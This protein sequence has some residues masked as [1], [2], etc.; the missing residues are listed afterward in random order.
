MPEINGQNLATVAHVTALAQRVK[1][2]LDGV[3]AKNF[4]DAKIEN[5]QLKLYAAVDASTPIK[6][7]DLP[8][9][10]YLD[11]VNTTFVGNFNFANGGYTGATNPNLDG[12]PVLVLAVKD[13]AT[14]P[15]VTY[16]FLNMES[17]V[18][19]YTALNDGIQITGYSIGVKTSADTDNL[20]SIANDGLL[21]GHDDTKIDTVAGAENNFVLFD[22]DGAIKDAGFTIA[23]T[24]DINTILDSI[25]GAAG[26]D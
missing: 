22:A 12:K 24:S 10:L 15:N 25:F 17:L 19:T 23:G 11:Q 4:S 3:D 5:G 8:A 2:E 7:I 18:D 9:D 16:S 26:G 20:L 1:T 6:T 13:N 21:V 14:S